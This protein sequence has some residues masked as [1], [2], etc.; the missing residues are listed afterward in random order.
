MRLGIDD[1][2][3]APEIVEIK[4]KNDE[5]LA[6]M[7]NTKLYEIQR[8]CDIYSFGAILFKMI[9]GK[10]YS[11]SYDGTILNSLVNSKIQ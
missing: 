10:N 2:T 8:K 3:A 4:S 9:F 5:Q 1:E 11:K 6:E 7:G